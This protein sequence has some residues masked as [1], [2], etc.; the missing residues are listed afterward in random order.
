VGGPGVTVSVTAA[1]IP[2]ELMMV[3]MDIRNLK[4]CPHKKM[5]L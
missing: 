3:L 5:I 2:G 4:K 1:T